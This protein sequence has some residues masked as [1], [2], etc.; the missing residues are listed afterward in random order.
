MPFKFSEN[1]EADTLESIDETFRPFYEETPEG[2]F[3]VSEKFKAMAG[4]WD[5][6]SNSV[7]ATRK[8]NKELKG[9]RVDLSGL[10][11]YGSTVDEIKAAFDGK[12]KELSDVIDSKKD[13]VNPE[14]IREQMREGISADLKAKDER[15]QGLEDQLYTTLVT[16]EAMT[17]ISAEKGN[18]TLL[19]PWI[20]KSVKM[21]EQDGKLIPRV[22]DAEG[23][24]RYGST[25]NPMTVREYVQGMKKDKTFAQLFEADQLPG[26]GKKPSNLPTGSPNPGGHQRMQSAADKIQAGIDKMRRG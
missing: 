21:F 12:V 3:V 5:G 20:Q 6:M 10:S 4:G 24:I 18:T 26:S 17:A 13:L 11:E 22:V 25:G 16:N 9:S 8:E 7:E 1:L 2:K 19:M 14:K 15:I 23:E